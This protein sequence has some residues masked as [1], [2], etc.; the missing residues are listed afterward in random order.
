MGD[1]TGSVLLRGRRPPVVL[2]ML[3]SVALVG[4]CTGLIYPLKHVTSVA[5]LGVV[6]LGVVIVSA[7]WGLSLGLATSILSA[8]AF[9]SLPSAASRPVHD[10][11]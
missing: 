1:D 3:V 8:A 6:Y 11:R 10:C 7:F 2:G 9:N 4:V 5:S